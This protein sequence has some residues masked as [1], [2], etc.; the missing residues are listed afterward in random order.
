MNRSDFL[1]PGFITY[2]YIIVQFPEHGGLG[3]CKRLDQLML[4]PKWDDGPMAPVG[5]WMVAEW[6]LQ[7][8]VSD[9]N[10]KLKHHLKPASISHVPDVPDLVEGRN[11]FVKLLRPSVVIPWVSPLGIC[12]GVCCRT[13][14]R[15][16]VPDIAWIICPWSSR[17]DF[18]W[19]GTGKIFLEVPMCLSL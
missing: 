3:L 10:H 18:W 4:F 11:W 5:G 6:S 1:S 8:V 17:R 14:P 7:L 2:I 16:A 12:P 19:D 13:S 15:S 9:F